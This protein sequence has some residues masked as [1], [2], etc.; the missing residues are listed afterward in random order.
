MPPLDPHA[1]VMSGRADPSDD[2]VPITPSDTFDLPYVSNA[3]RAN[4]AGTVVVFTVRGGSGSPRTLNFGAGETR[5][6]RATRV[7]ATGTTA[8]GLE[9]HV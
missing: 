3:I 8:T 4:G 5:A 9:A 2:V 7:L 1:N 6:V